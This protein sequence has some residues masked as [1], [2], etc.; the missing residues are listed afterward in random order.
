MELVAVDENFNL[1]NDVQEVQPQGTTDSTPLA[2]RPPP[3]SGGGGNQGLHL[4]PDTTGGL[5]LT[6]TSTRA[7]LHFGSRPGG[8]RP[9]NKVLGSND[10][11]GDIT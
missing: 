11:E 1:V 3:H 7:P 9:A 8:G 10:G 6:T 4:T 2:F 5:R